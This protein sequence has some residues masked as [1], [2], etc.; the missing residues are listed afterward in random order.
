MIR[1]RPS[2]LA[3][4]PGRPPESPHDIDEGPMRREL[5]RQIALLEQE[6]TFGIARER[7]WAMPRTSRRRGPAWQ[8]AAALEE[9]RDELVRA[10]GDLRARGEQ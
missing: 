5:L 2:D 9:I 7:T 10:I 1:R 6:L 8:D 3:P 4:P